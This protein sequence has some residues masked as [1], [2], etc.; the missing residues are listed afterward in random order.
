MADLMEMY[1]RTMWSYKSIAVDRIIAEMKRARFDD[2]EFTFDGEHHLLK[3]ICRPPDVHTVIVEYGIITGQIEEDVFGKLRIKPL[4]PDGSV[5]VPDNELIEDENTYTT[6]TKAGQLES[7]AFPTSISTFTHTAVWTKLEQDTSGL[8]IHDLINKNDL[9]QLQKDTNVVMCSD[10]AETMIYLGGDDE[11]SI[12]NATQKL[13][14]LLAGKKLSSS[15]TEHILYSGAYVETGDYDITADTRYLYNIEPKLFTSTLLDR[16]KFDDL[17]EAYRRICQGGSS[18]RLC[19]FDAEKKH[20]IS[21]F[22]PQIIGIPTKKLVLGNRPVIS[23]KKDEGVK[24]I[25]DP[26]IDTAFDKKDATTSHREPETGN[27]VRELLQPTT[28]KKPLKTPEDQ[29]F[30]PRTIEEVNAVIKA[31]KKTPPLEAR[32]DYL[33]VSKSV[34][35]T[36]DEKQP[37]ICPL[38]LRPDG[39]GIGPTMGQNTKARKKPNLTLSDSVESRTP[40]RSTAESNINHPATRVGPSFPI[41]GYGQLI[42]SNTFS[43][44]IEAAMIRMLQIAPYLRGKVAMQVEF[45]RAILLDMDPTAIAFNA[46][47]S[48]SNG[49]DKEHLVRSLNDQMT[50]PDKIHFTKVLT[51]FASDVE[52]MIKESCFWQDSPQEAWTVYSFYCCAAGTMGPSQFIV[53]IKDVGKGVDNFYY[54]I[55]RC[56]QE[57]REDGVAHIYVHALY[58]SWDFRMTMS[59]T[60]NIASEEPFAAFAAMLLGSLE[61]LKL[62]NGIELRFAV[63]DSLNVAIRGVRVLTKWRYLSLNSRSALDITEVEQLDIEP[64]VD[65]CDRASAR[66]WKTDEARKKKKTGDFPR[67]YEASIVSTKAERLLLQN[68][69]LRVGEKAGWDADI[70]KEHGVLTDIYG[71]ALHTLKHMAHVGGNDDNNATKTEKI[72]FPKPSK[73][74][75]STIPGNLPVEKNKGSAKEGSTSSQKSAP[76]Q[77]SIQKSNATK[78]SMVSKSGHL[79]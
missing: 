7:L 59:H 34:P 66:P 32:K 1:L 31:S 27:R 43:K 17:E 16:S 28:S 69:T 23:T 67:W 11:S 39:R 70:L 30:A 37:Y 68:D 6:S 77:T 56:D 46:P 8:T 36:E 21:M 62:G 38:P 13:E 12:E 50:G 26:K 22:G 49:W 58:N 72:A 2:A 10:H 35:S 42:A 78:A 29:I 57:Q 14:I 55:R 71:P 4:N 60:D 53:D 54:S 61:V 15:K 63:H 40:P 75:A 48:K 9:A 65:G 3:V 33:K 64:L 76:T 41:V 51:T 79:W 52:Y 44:E 5:K 20:H 73:E 74:D 25:T 19:T 47:H 24:H 18:I 45:G